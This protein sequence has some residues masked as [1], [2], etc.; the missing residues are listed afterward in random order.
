LRLLLTSPEE[1][2]RVTDLA[3][4]AK[5]SKGYASRVVAELTAMQ[6][7][8]RD[9]D[10][11]HVLDAELLLAKWAENYVPSRE[12][13]SRYFARMDDPVGALSDLSQAA[14]RSVY[15][16]AA[17]GPAGASLVDPFLRTRDLHVFWSGPAEIVD[18]WPGLRRADRG[19]NV[20][21][22]RPYDRFVYFGSRLVQGMPVVSD[23]Q[24]YLDL[25]RMG[26]RAIEQAD[27]F[28]RRLLGRDEGGPDR[29]HQ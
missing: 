21:V 20:L 12:T 16:W 8:Y 13:V 9:N 18:H 2:W 7:V 29:S 1:G 6:W 28:R 27:R 5:L 24:L 17:T 10:T 4:Q 11:V 23:L 14:D 26:D 15:E 25:Q 3:R 19:A 22:Y